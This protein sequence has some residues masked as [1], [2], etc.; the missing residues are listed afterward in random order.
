LWDEFGNE[1]SK[2]NKTMVVLEGD[3]GKQYEKFIVEKPHNVLSKDANNLILG[4]RQHLIKI[5]RDVKTFLISFIG[6][7]EMCN[8]LQTSYNY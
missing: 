8:K 2:K 5:D 4:L 1:F 3:E 6:L 7:K